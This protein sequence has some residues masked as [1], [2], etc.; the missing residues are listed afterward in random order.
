MSEIK[1]LVFD[2]DGTLV[3]RSKQTVQDSAVVA[4][5]ELRAKGMHILVAT[6]R[7]FFFI[8][9]DVRDRINTEFYVSVNG[10]CL[11]DNKGNV[12]ETHGMN[13]DTLEKFI[14]YCR[15]NNYPV[16]VKYPDHI[17]VY[18]D[19]DNYVE[20]YTGVA[21]GRT[22]LLKDDN[23][24]KSYLTSIPLGAYTMAPDTHIEKI[25]AN[26]KDLYFMPTDYSTVE[27]T[28][29]GVDKTKTIA[30]V[31]ERLDLTWDNV[32]T[33]GDGNNDIEMLQ[34]AKVGIAMG[35][36]NDFVKSHADYVTDT[37]LNDGIVKG[38]KH[39]NLI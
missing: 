18:G 9:D 29:I 23:D 1:L 7:S 37:V 36:A 31:I 32:V 38:L 39:L 8:H 12:L 11:T 22:H 35:N 3:D 10:A 21:H 34:L 2:I 20:N 6:G 33:F 14:D 17:G 30:E 5:N 4:I 28:S 15:E 16:G 19:Y 13:K 25:R 26:F 24:K 27:A